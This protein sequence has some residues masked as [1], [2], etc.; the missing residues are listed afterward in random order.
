[1][2]HEEDRI[3]IREASADDE[4]ILQDLRTSVGWSTAD[5]GLPAMLAGRSVVYILELDHKPA[6]SGALVFRA[7]AADLADG[8]QRALISNLIVD[9]AYQSHGLGTTVLDYLEEQVRGRD[10]RIVNIGVDMPNIR[11]RALYERHGYHV[12]TERV[13]AWGPVI[14][15]TKRLDNS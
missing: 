11:A 4:Q 9:A 10:F 8:E 7:D 15:L 6:A 3:T 5:T 2:E 1:M 12:L 14:Y 13:E